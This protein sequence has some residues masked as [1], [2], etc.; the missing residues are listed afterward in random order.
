MNSSKLT[1]TEQIF[2]KQS[3][4]EKI[5]FSDVVVLYNFVNTDYNLA[6]LAGF[7]ASGYKYAKEALGKHPQLDTDVEIDCFEMMVDFFYHLKLLAFNLQDEDGEDAFLYKNSGGEIHNIRAWVDFFFN[8]DTPD[9]LLN[10]W[11]GTIRE[12]LEAA[13]SP[14]NIEQTR[15]ILKFMRLLGIALGGG[16]DAE[17]FKETPI[18]V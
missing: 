4:A 18:V 3:I 7:A 8:V 14:E 6:K 5:T 17:K 12:V 10:N 13:M 15:E 11:I 16:I 2:K 9:V 1:K